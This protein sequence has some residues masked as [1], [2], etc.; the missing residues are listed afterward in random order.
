MSPVSRQNVTN[1]LLGERLNPGLLAFVHAA[2]LGSFV[3]AAEHLGMSPS[4]VAKAIQRFESNVGT[5]LFTRTTRSLSLTET[6][7]VLF[8]HAKRILGVIAEAEA[9]MAQK[10]GRC[11]GTLRVSL[12]PAVGKALILPSLASYRRRYP[13]VTLE[14]DFEP[15]IV[16]VVGGG[17]DVAL[18]TGPLP[19]SALRARSVGKDRLTLCASPGYAARYGLPKTPKELA[20]H[21][22][23]RFR[24]PSS[25]RVRP[26]QL[27][28]VKDPPT[29]LPE[30]LVFSD[31]DAIGQALMH[32]LGIAFASDYLAQPG[33]REGRLL[34]VLPDEVP[35]VTGHERW[36]VWPSSRQSL[37]VRSFIDHVI[38]LFASID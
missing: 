18:R 17:F 28:G 29:V 1:L 38:E 4:G 32:G 35:H 23:I 3:R 33:I 34:R 37:K 36:L 5:P 24:P 2:Q 16:D 13:M 19:D 9:A 25:G 21:S 26:W 11:S 7:V 6:G 27:A 14:V 8:E 12:A 22:L 20:Q 15:R 30:T 31:P 10:A